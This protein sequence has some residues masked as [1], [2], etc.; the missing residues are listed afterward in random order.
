MKL[1]QRLTVISFLVGGVSVAGA[2]VPA[3]KAVSAGTAAAGKVTQI[4]RKV[5]A[6]TFARGAVTLSLIHI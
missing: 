4:Q 1:L 5:A 6:K 2:Q 3:G